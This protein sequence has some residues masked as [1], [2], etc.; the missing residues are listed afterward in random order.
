VWTPRREGYRG[1]GTASQTVF[2]DTSVVSGIAHWYKVQ[3]CN[4]GGCSTMSTADF[5]FAGELQRQVPPS[6]IPGLGA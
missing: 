6:A 1:I 4:S 2:G 3:A 5:G